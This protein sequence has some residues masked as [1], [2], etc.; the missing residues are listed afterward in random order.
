MFDIDHVPELAPRRLHHIDA[1]V[2]RVIVREGIR[3]RIG[4]SVEL[5]IRFGEGVVLACYLDAVAR[6][7][8]S[9]VTCC[10]ARGMPART[11][12]SATRSWNRARSVSTVPTVSA[13]PAK[14]WVR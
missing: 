3:A 1:V 6:A 14:G 4:E 2:D 10:S 11:V 7:A 9:G 5:A 12:G 8:T 13:R